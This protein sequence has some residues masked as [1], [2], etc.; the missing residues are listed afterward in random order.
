MKD[1]VVRASLKISWAVLLVTMWVYA[2]L[3]DN[4]MP[5][6]F[7]LAMWITARISA[8]AV[9][10]VKF[11]MENA[12]RKKKIDKDHSQETAFWMRDPDQW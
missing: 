8:D 5:V 10:G 7:A 4:Y 3:N 9:L 6:M 12:G 2:T 11:F 1:A